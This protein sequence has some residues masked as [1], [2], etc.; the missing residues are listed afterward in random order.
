MR[1][2]ELLGRRG[3]IP[4][5]I[6]SLRDQ[7]E[8]GLQNYRSRNMAEARL[9]FAKCLEIFPDDGPAKLFLHRIEV[10]EAQAPDENWDGVWTM[11]EK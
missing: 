8:R 5:Q 6:A 4:V 7:Y 1:I 10:F 3:N 9:A 11:T 2:Y